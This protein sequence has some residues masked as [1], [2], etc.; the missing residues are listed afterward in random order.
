L[1]V[2]RGWALP[3]VPEGRPEEQGR[4]P[5]LAFVTIRNVSDT[6]DRLTAASSPIAERAELRDYRMEEGKRVAR[7]VAAID[8]PAG[9]TLTLRPDGPHVALLGL[10][11]DLVQGGLFPLSLEFANAGTVAVDVQVRR[12]AGPGGIPKTRGGR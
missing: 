10:R 11:G 4:G 8:I 12:M 5:G 7:R 2:S 3:T 1:I 9:R 6:A